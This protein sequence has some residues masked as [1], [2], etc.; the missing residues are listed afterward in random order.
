MYKTNRERKKQLIL[1]NSGTKNMY[2]LMKML[3]LIL[4]SLILIITFFEQW[5]IYKQDEIK[6]RLFGDWDIMCFDIEEDDLSYFENN[7][8]IDN[9]SIQCVLEKVFI[10]KE[11][12][13]V[14]GSTDENFLKLSN[15][16]LLKG[17]MPE[18]ED[19]VAIEEQYLR[20]LNV[21]NVGDVI[22]KDSLID[23]LRGYK[24]C[25]ILSN[26]SDRWK[27]VNWDIKFINCFTKYSRKNANQIFI[28][29]SEILKKDIKNNMLYYRQNVNS[30][31]INL[32]YIF[33]PLIIMIILIEILLYI[34]IN[35]LISR[36]LNLSFI[37]VNSLKNKHVRLLIFVLEIVLSL[38]LVLFSINIMNEKNIFNQVYDNYIQNQSVLNT[39]IN[40]ENVRIIFKFNDQIKE[41]SVLKIMSNST[42]LVYLIKG[43][44]FFILILID[45]YFVILLNSYN[46]EYI[47][48][49]N[50]YFGEKELNKKHVKSEI[51]LFVFS[52]VIS[53]CLLMFLYKD[54][55][56]FVIVIN[57]SIIVSTNFFIRIFRLYCYSKRKKRIINHLS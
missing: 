37:R 7:A 34:F 44:F 1:M 30:T 40:K 14:V 55:V 26:Y 33:F 36:Y 12:R 21:D 41:F 25:G 23:S 13:V 57:I 52:S 35:V 32:L 38:L 50:Y 29:G 46:N 49:L 6:D 45:N 4:I 8:F 16:V 51:Y 39:I 24:V 53:S 15:I 20:F 11:Q 48:L 27:K 47:K 2:F 28:S 18:N 22:P 10:N 19:E 42:L 9:Y 31:R 43:I 5:I 17:K 3:L 54:I 56:F